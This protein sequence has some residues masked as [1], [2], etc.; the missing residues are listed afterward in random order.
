MLYSTAARDGVRT[1]G[2]AGALLAML[3]DV[4]DLG[5]SRDTLDPHEHLRGLLASL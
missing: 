1:L 4:G 5:T 2:L 3:W